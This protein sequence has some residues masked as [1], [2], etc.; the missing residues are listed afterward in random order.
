M[1]SRHIMSYVL[2]GQGDKHGRFFGRHVIAIELLQ[3]SPTPSTIM[4]ALI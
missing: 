4:D 2:R 3:R 1:A